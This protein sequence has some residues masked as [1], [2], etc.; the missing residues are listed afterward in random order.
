MEPVASL[1]FGG[2][3]K[4][5]PGYTLMANPRGTDVAP[6][7]ATT[8]SSGYWAKRIIASPAL[9]DC[10]HSAHAREGGTERFSNLLRFTQPGSSRA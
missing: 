1:M 6:R 2:P 10:F 3:R 4:S 8:V 9:A 7:A 5:H